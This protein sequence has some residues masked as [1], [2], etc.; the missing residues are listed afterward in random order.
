M[1]NDDIMKQ[2]GGDGVEQYL[3]KSGMTIDKSIH[4]HGPDAVQVLNLAQKVFD[5]N[6]PKLLDDAAKLSEKRAVKLFC[7]LL[8]YPNIDIENLKKK[9]AEPAMQIS[10]FEA[11]KQYAKTGDDDLETLL[12]EIL[13]Q[14]AN[15][16]ERS[17]E[18]IVLD[19]A[20]N[21]TSKL[22]RGQ[23]AILTLIFAITR[24]RRLDDDNVEKLKNSIN[25]NILIFLDEVAGDKSCYEHLEYASCVSIMTGANH[26]NVEEIFRLI[27]PGLFSN[28]FTEERLLAE[29]GCVDEIKFIISKSLHFDDKLQF[30]VMTEDV[31]RV[32]LK[33]KKVS[34]EKINKCCELFKSTL[35]NNIQAKKA[36]IDIN[37][38][39]DKLFELWK[40]TQLRQ[41]RLSSVGI[42]IAHTNYVQKTGVKSDLSTWIK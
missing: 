1:I 27:Y 8:N 39:M 15:A 13:S 40:N 2:E 10:V 30:M 11:Q 6:Y 32:E 4:M 33:L 34:E 7:D 41:L 12:V 29:I 17:L 19:E 16:E 18:Q 9:L 35:M 22:T 23:I 24:I 5:L 20:I 36:L 28:G 42:A 21:V 37:S 25:N 26:K 3:S 14:R 38:N 31:L